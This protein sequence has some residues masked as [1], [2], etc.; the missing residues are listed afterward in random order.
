MKLYYTGNSPYARRARLAV[1]AGGLGEVV[2]V[3]DAADIGHDEHAL[4]ELGAGGKVPGLAIDDDLYLCETLVIT[5]Y[6]NALAD[7]RL[8]PEDP[9]ARAR[10]PGHDPSPRLE[11][12]SRPRGR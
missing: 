3:V 8:L 9:L 7:G 11:W 12:P 4:R 6:L 5:Q 2:E 10:A 1:H